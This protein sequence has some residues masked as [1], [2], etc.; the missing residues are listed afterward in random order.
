MFGTSNGQQRAGIL[1]A[2][3]SHELRTPLN[4]ILGW[5]RV[6]R[7]EGSADGD[8]DRAVES[9]ERNSR[10]Q[11]TIVAD[12]LDMSRIVSGRIRLDLRSLPRLIP[13]LALGDARCWVSYYA[14][15]RIASSAAWVRNPL[16]V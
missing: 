8:F 15:F 2:T 14:D 7:H 5:A 11:A 13:R 16:R 1:L 12:L 10:L 9:I 6:L 3:L 4:A